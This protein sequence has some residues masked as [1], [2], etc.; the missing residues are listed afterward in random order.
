MKKF[1]LSIL[2]TLFLGFWFIFAQ[3][4]L[5]DSADISVKD[6]IIMWEATN[7]KITILKNGSKMTSYNGTIRIIVTDEDWNKLKDNEYTV[8]S[9][10]TY[11]FLWS[12]L[13]TK[14][15]QRWLEIKKEGTFYIEVQDLNE[16][17]DKI[18]WKQLIHV[19]KKSTPDDVK[20]IEVLN[21]IPNANLIWDKIEIIWTAT[22]I[23]NSEAIIYIDE[24]ETWTTKVDSNWIIN[25][26][27]WNVAAWQHSLLLEIPDLAWNVMWRSDKIFFTI[28]P[29]WDSW[30]KNVLIEPEKGLMIWDMTSI[31]AYTDDM[32]ESV[33][34]KL[35]DR[36]END[37]MVMNKVWIWEF[38]QNVRLIGS[39]EISLSFETASSNNS[40]IQKY[41]DYKRFS[42]WDLPY[43]QNI[44]INTDAINRSADI[45]REV[46]NSSVVS[47]YLIDRWVEWSNTLSWKDRSDKPAF[48]FS[49]V[50]YDTI[51]NLNITPYRSN[52]SKHWAA[53]KT[54]Q[55]VITKNQTDWCWNGICE[56]WE[57][58]E[59]CP[60]DCDWEWWATIIPR[61][62]CSQDHVSVRTTKIWDS[63]Y[64]VRDKIEN[65]KK[66]LIYSSSSPDWKDKTKVYETTDTSYEY[67]FDHNSKED[68]YMYFWIYWI[69]E[70][71]EEL[72]L[73]WATKVQVWPAENFFLLMCLTLLIY[74]W[75]KLFR[76]TE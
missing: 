20:Y 62:S 46:L 15:F 53:S 74:S 52:E 54:I 4:I 42:V 23:P 67:P 75:I 39:W 76:Q 1:I 37:S 6:P 51:V 48:R 11:A 36:P 26:T 71:W 60:Q 70:D 40:V 58:H 33:K 2:T 45:S 55:F 49:D 32:I 47:S 29:A 64:L 28:S 17:E 43:I 8:P 41:D 10:W 44:K 35:S 25:Y 61:R 12:D 57:S 59:L 72:E 19:I 3:N 68:V 13:W 21:P 14:E 31:T 9:Q 65:V 30:I 5:P 69:C 18:L 38:N 22:D 24:K 66:Y 73:T 50:P 27:I 34:M 56:D 16:N 63:Y 7:L